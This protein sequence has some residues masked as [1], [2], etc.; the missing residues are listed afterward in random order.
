M[1]KKKVRKNND[2]FILSKKYLEQKMKRRNFSL[3]FLSCA[4]NFLVRST[5]GT[6]KGHR[7]KG[8]YPFFSSSGKPFLVPPITFSFSKMVNMTKRMLEYEC[9]CLSDIILFKFSK[10]V[11]I[12]KR[13]LEYEWCLLK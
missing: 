5:G 3:L 11:N 1:C 7:G 4:P 10:M 8:K 13:M 12:R 2:E 6:K 9:V